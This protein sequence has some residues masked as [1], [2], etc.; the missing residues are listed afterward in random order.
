MKYTIISPVCHAVSE[1][2]GNAS[3]FVVWAGWRGWGRPEH[4]TIYRVND[5]HSTGNLISIKITPYVKHVSLVQKASGNSGRCWGRPGGGL[6]VQ[7]CCVWGEQTCFPG[8][9]RG[10]V[11]QD[12][13]FSISSHMD[14]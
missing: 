6:Q 5:H 7:C 14:R 13:A 10:E 8:E 4:V 1:P 2:R 9:F 12:R 11:P 3:L